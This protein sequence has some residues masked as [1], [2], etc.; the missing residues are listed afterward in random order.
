MSRLTL[1]EFENFFQYYQ[2]ETHQ[3]DAVGELWR[4]MPV[5]LLEEDTD[6]IVKYRS[7]PAKE[8]HSSGAIS[9]INAAGL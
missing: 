8:E 7:A 1:Q 5:D 9:V 4:R 6:W 3:M 2:G